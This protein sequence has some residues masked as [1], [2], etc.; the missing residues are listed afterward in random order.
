MAILVQSFLNSAT[1]ISTTA[2]TAT[3]VSQ[4]KTLMNTAEG[5]STAT[6]QFY[7][8]NPSTTATLLIS[9]TLGS[10]GIT[11]ATT[12]YSSNTISTAT[13]K[14]DRQLA[15]LELAQLR[16]QA[17]GNTSTNY[18]RVY[19]VYDINL[20]A[21][22]YTSNTSTVGTTST[23]AIHRPWINPP[24]VTANLILNLDPDNS[25]S[26]PGS[27]TTYTDIA[28]TAQNLTL[29][30][31]PTYTSGTPSYFTFN[32]TNQYGLSASTGIVNTTAY[33]KSAYFY[34]NGYQDNNIFSGDGHFIYMGPQANIDRKIYSGHANWGSFTAY[35]SVATINLNT[36]YN[37]TLTFSTTNGMTLYINGVLD[38]TYTAQKTAHPGTGTASIAAYGSGNLLN[39]RIGKVL[40]YNTELSAA[41]VL[42]NFNATRAIYGL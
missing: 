32:G 35:P 29:Y 1:Q 41:Q 37:V 9:G 7:I 31:S 23:L 14:V 30:G 16:R 17:G 20:L 22:K 11:T 26:Y 8:I 2:T 42:Q 13:N 40:C 36:W 34:L 12:I 28:G 10:Y 25:S 27:G 39:G 4:L 21:D 6:M 24:I 33:T 19:N 3:T 18:Y 15:K 5:V 38:S